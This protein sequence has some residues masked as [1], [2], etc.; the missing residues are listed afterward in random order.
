[1]SLCTKCLITHCLEPGAQSGFVSE[2]NPV[3]DTRQRPTR[4]KAKRRNKASP[5]VR[6][7]NTFPVDP[8]QVQQAYTFLGLQLPAALFQVKPATASTQPHHTQAIATAGAAVHSGVAEY[9]RNVAEGGVV[10]MPERAHG[11]YGR[12]KDVDADTSPAVTSVV[13][14][15]AR[16][17]A[18]GAR[19]AAAMMP[20]AAA[21]GP[22]L[23]PAAAAVVLEPA[24]LTAE[25]ACT[26]AVTD[27]PPAYTAQMDGPNDILHVQ[28]QPQQGTEVKSAT[29]DAGVPPAA[30]EQKGA[31]QQQLAGTLSAVASTNAL[32][33]QPL[34][35]PTAA[36]PLLGSL[37]D[38]SA[39]DISSKQPLGYHVTSD[40][41]QPSY[42][43]QGCLEGS[44]LSA[45]ASKRG[46]ADNI[47][48][49]AEA[50]RQKLLPGMLAICVWADSLLHVHV[51]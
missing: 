34:T 21:A 25:A 18:A 4:K 37:V 28:P 35:P 27:A 2:S 3:E 29:T 22:S 39:R 46:Q 41:R 42:A 13:P 9:L 14:E 15:T 43:T 48:D 19:D 51:A 5:F 11:D 20:A 26:A 44:A 8:D 31:S 12:A 38:T 16:A 30:D 7:H 1:M 6:L 10:A 50:K 36:E 24:A 32:Q 49:P 45:A 33:L 47:S 17:S 23:T 40:A